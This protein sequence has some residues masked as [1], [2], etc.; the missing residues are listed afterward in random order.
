MPMNNLLVLNYQKK[1]FN[2]IKSGNLNKPKHLGKIAGEEI[3][4][5]AENN[6]IKK[7]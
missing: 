3:L 5:K 2:V 7:K 1:V 6:F 4:K